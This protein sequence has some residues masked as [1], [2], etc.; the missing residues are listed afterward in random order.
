VSAVTRTTTLTA[1][2]DTSAPLDLPATRAQRRGDVMRDAS[3]RLTIHIHSDLN[4]IESEWRRFERVADCTA[5]QTFDWLAT[6]QRHIGERQG[7]RPVIVVGHFGDGDIAFIVPLGVERGALARR[8][9]WLGQDLC[10]YNAPL[11][12][13]DFSARVTPQA[14]LAAWHELQLQASCEPPLRFDWVEFEK[15]PETVGSQT[16]PFIYLGV[17]ANPSNAHLTHLGDD[18]EKFYFAK[19]SSATRR[20]D[21]AKRR[22]MSEYGDVRFL[23]AANAEDARRTLEALMEQKSR[24]LERKG[25]P[26]IFAPP[27]HREFYLELASNPQARHLV[28]V[29]HVEIGD[30]CAAANFGMV[31]GD[32]YYHVLASYVDGEVAHYG[33]GALHLRELM[34]YAIDRGLRRFDFTIGDEPYKLEWSDSV[35]KLYDCTTTKNWRGVPARFFSTARRRVKRLIKQT[36]LL[37]NLTSQ[38]RATVASFSRPARPA[39]H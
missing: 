26:D 30:M 27:G 32:C 3:P 25:I 5:F 21:R 22:H 33:P 28:H 35:L 29:S 4:T 12:A 9:C 17:T 34:A 14:F 16:N 6:W 10:D 24:S 20:R 31:H 1:F 11:L 7:V 38:A 36:P 2:P 13:R 23:S 15:M 37:W 18:W 8:L 39:C 19:R